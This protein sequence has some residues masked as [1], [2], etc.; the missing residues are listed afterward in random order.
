MNI[1]ININICMFD[2]DGTIIEFNLKSDKY[3][4]LYSNTLIKF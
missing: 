4:L 1:N 2:L 3:Q